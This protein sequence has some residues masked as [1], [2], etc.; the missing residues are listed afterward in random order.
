[1][2]KERIKHE[3]FTTR[4]SPLHM[5]IKL[6]YETDGTCFFRQGQSAECRVRFYG[7]LHGTDTKRQTKEGERERERGKERE[8]ASA[9][10]KLKKLVHCPTRRKWVWPY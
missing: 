6:R 5:F 3:L 9:E 2:N 8:R 4:T 10:W 1:M 7:G